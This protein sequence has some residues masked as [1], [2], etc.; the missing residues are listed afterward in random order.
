M[1]LPNSLRPQPS[2]AE[3][4]RE[5]EPGEEVIFTVYVRPKLSAPAL[6]DLEFWQQTPLNERIFLS[7]E[8]YGER[9]GSSK[10]DMDAV[11][12]LFEQHGMSI[13]SQ[14]TG[15]GAIE[16]RAT[17]AQVTSEFG[18]Q[19]NHYKAPLPAASRKRRNPDDT[20]ETYRGFTGELS[21][22]PMLQ[23][24]VIRV[25]GLDTRT[26]GASG[27][28]S[29]DPQNSNRR[30]VAEIAALYSFPRNI[31][32]SDQTIGV[33]SGEGADE[34]GKSLSNYSPTDLAAY[35]KNQE[36]GYGAQPKLVP[37]ALSVGSK[38]Y[39]NDPSNPTLEL[40][41]DIMTLATIAQG[42]T[43]NVYFSDLTEQGWVSFLNRVLFPA[44]GERRPNVVSMSW[45]MYDEKTYGPNISFLFQRLAVV[46]TS[47]FGISGDWGANSN[48]IDGH[49]HVGW[50]GSDPWV[51]CVGGTVVGNVSAEP[52]PT[53]DE[54]AWSDRDNT[55]S[56]FT[57]D[58]TLGT[59]GGGMS[60]I[61][62]T[63][64][65][66][67]AVG[68]SAYEDSTSKV[69]R[70]GRFVPDIAG[71]VGLRG[72][73]TGGKRNYFVGTSCS[74]PLYAGLFA[75]VSSILR[76][77]FGLLNPTLYQLGDVVCRDVAFGHNDSGDSPCCEYFCA[78]VGY[79]PVTGLGS[80]DGTKLLN[81]LKEMY[82]WQMCNL[83]VSTLPN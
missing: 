57:I 56:Q 35:F 71:M 54:Y 80:L 48:V 73:I 16:V 55:S 78:G 45:T 31:N 76:Q 52:K 21:L 83:G 26:F 62:P 81:A 5:A 40:S 18:V 8:E 82:S 11:A 65:Y 69:W 23:G 36:P 44:E 4:I 75:A 12:T 14:H 24:R 42:C 34:D 2:N 39:C 9:Y 13:R 15:Q 17:A 46:G 25:F 60:V 37:V 33:F 41:Q 70:G 6:P 30:T 72:F 74:T 59:T 47:V 79:D 58:G 51:T 63:P 49:A 50:P 19:M 10:E 27:G 1:T 53:F 68:I 61:F 7:P 22:S 43:I 3:H 66:Q 67:S 32:A 28:Y 77:P 64:A 20:H 38:K 29:G